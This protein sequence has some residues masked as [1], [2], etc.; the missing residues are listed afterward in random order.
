MTTYYVSNSGSNSNSGTSTVN[1]WRT[2][3][4]VN[5]FNFS[6]SD[7]IYFKGGDTFSDAA[8][9][10]ISH[11]GT[12]G[13]YV[14]IGSYGSGKATL[15]GNWGYNDFSCGYNPYFKVVDG[16]RYFR[17]ENLRLTLAEVAYESEN[18]R[19]FEV[20]DVDIDRICRF[21]IRT[22][23]S[24][25]LLIDGCTTDD[26]AREWL[27]GSNPPWP[28]NL[29]IGSDRAIIRDT[30]VTDCYG[31]GIT[32]SGEDNLV[33]GC[34]CVDNWSESI[35]VIDSNKSV[36]RNNLILGTTNNDFH[37]YNHNGRSFPG[38][39][40]SI[41]KEPGSNRPGI[42]I[43]QNDVYNNLCARV[44]SLARFGNDRFGVNVASYCNVVYNTVVDCAHGI[45]RFMD[46]TKTGNRVQN[47]IVVDY[48][49]DTDMYQLFQGG[50][51]HSGY[52]F[53]HNHWS[54]QSQI[55]GTSFADNTNTYGNPR[56]GKTSGWM[57]ISDWRNITVS[58]FELQ[59]NSPCLNQGT[60]ITGREQRAISDF[61]LDYNDNARDSSPHMGALE[62]AG[63]PP[64][65]PPEPLY[66][67]RSI[68]YDK[69]RQLRM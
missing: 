27:D 42:P 59:G 3:G 6:T 14:I 48:S 50:S 55:S 19:D 5:S 66:V 44:Y 11:S 4:K 31:E 24:Q 69:I 33:E 65:P 34:T 10:R 38:G 7:R 18:C 68:S 28:G 1:P 2:V 32:P 49:G 57:S 37:R 8:E 51:G 26:T 64:P 23:G 25:D 67:P 16:T 53:S 35:Y 63:A 52:V 58:D 15:R 17:V 61:G 13:N 60:D 30:V 47:N 21:S 41:V 39:A 9:L 62:D 40:F 12:S 54:N 22:R 45:G 20:V 56:L 36:I 43:T 46:K 29:S